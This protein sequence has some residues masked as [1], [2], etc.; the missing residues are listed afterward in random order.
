MTC[1]WNNP[2]LHDEISIAEWFIGDGA[3]LNVIIGEV[4]TI[5]VQI[6]GQCSQISES[7]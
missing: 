6:S 2:K 7:N 1:V 3:I 5:R 4:N